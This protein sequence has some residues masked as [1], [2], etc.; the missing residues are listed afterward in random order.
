VVCVA[1]IAY[2]VLRH[3]EGRALIRARR[4]ALNAADI[5]RL[6]AEHG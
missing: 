1:L 2:E 4:G 3:H 6:E 5:S